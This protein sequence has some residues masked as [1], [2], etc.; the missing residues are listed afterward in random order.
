M[1][2]QPPVDMTVKRRK[3]PEPNRIHWKAGSRFGKLDAERVM[4]DVRRLKEPSPENLYT[5]SR[6]KKHSLHALIWAEDD[7]A[8]AQR[9]RI[10][11]CREVLRGLVETMVIGGAT[12]EVRA[13][14]F[15]KPESRPDGVWGTV[16]EIILDDE[17]RDAYL[18]AA[19]Q[20][21]LS[22]TAKLRKVRQ[23]L[24]AAT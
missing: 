20:L 23:L 10:E 6:A 12:I 21:M 14:E 8:W 24:S 9:G 13:V 18:L 17:M 3:E 16:D 11:K 2:I 22:A 7:E 5:A 4:K 19:E 15:V 1:N